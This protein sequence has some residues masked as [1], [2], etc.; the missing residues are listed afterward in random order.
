MSVSKYSHVARTLPLTLVAA[1]VAVGAV[2]GCSDDNDALGGDV[3]AGP[4]SSSSSSSGSSGGGD[5]TGCRVEEREVKVGSDTFCCAV[6]KGGDTTSCVESEGPRAGDSCSASDTPPEPNKVLS[7]TTDSCVSE[8]CN[9]DLETVVFNAETE[10]IER[11]LQCNTT[12]KEWEAAGSP[13]RT[14][15][16]LRVCEQ[17]ESLQCNGGY[18]Y[19]A[20]GGHTAVQRAV[21]VLESTCTD[22]TGASSPCPA[23]DL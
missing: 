10:V 4:T 13:V 9:G 14:A 6:T 12:T 8:T 16:V 2:Q 15:T 19:G 11:Q 22:S 1:L 3:D 18:G 23:G 7:I 17:S 21:T 20:Y 5:A